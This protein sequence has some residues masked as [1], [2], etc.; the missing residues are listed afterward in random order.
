MFAQE[1][2]AMLSDAHV[3]A[4]P[5]RRSAQ[6][7]VRLTL[8]YDGTTFHGFAEQ[9]DVRTVGGELRAA[10][11]RVL[12]GAVTDFA[13]AGRTDA[14]VHAQGQVVSFATSS[15]RLDVNRLAV[16]LT[17]LLGPEIVVWQAEVAPDG[18]D[19]R[20]SATARH[21]EYSI[22]Q[23]PAPDPLRASWQ[24]HVGA[25]LDIAAM[26][27]AAVHFVGEHDFR[28]FC[29][30]LKPVASVIG[31]SSAVRGSS[32]RASE[33]TVQPI[34]RR[35]LAASWREQPAPMEGRLLTFDICANAFCH[36]MVRSIV[37]FCA[38]VGQ[39][40]RQADEVPA[41]LAAADRN[42]AGTVAPPHGLTLMHVS[43]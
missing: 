21:Y 19:A 29:R 10:L 3:G 36:Q 38:D 24:W 27:E 32:G 26:N 42:A 12:G 15:E 22:R 9:R 43:Y 41:V 28:S 34:N 20:H 39:G 31:S 25:E 40:R 1:G 18:F 37:G 5:Q 16:T 7:R 11:Q 14:G 2:A 13:V 33:R 4:Y 23:A 17:K 6:R 30:A 8:A 35:V